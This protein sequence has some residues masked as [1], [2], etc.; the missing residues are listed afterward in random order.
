MVKTQKERRTLKVRVRKQLKDNKLCE[1]AFDE[2]EGDVEVQT[3]LEDSNRMAIDRLGYSDHGH[4]HSLI[5][6]MNGMKL[7]RELNKVIKPRK[8]GI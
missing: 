5:V 8:L 4:T 6:T 2:L 1:I 3:L 7:F